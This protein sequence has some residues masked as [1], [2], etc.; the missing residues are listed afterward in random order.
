MFKAK[1]AP[2]RYEKVLTFECVS[3]TQLWVSP[4]VYARTVWIF[5]V[6][7]TEYIFRPLYSPV[8]EEAKWES[9]MAFP[10]ASY[11]RETLL[12]TFRVLSSSHLPW[13][14]PVCTLEAFFGGAKVMVWNVRKIGWYR[15]DCSRHNIGKL[16]HYM[17]KYKNAK[18][19][20]G[21]FPAVLFSPSFREK[22]AEKICKISLFRYNT[23]APYNMKGTNKVSFKVS[24]KKRDPRP[25]FSL[26]VLP[27]YRK[28][29]I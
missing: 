12:S 2:F 8:T 10:S 15:T 13:R 1:S 16:P 7:P 3:K 22:K 11:W 5:L 25:S 4:W 14:F 19:N 28:T 9:P 6:F 24:L 17:E 29:R 20:A 23:P 27:C 21:I 26:S 18:K